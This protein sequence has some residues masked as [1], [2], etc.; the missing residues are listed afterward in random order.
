MERKKQNRGWMR[1]ILSE[2]T[3]GLGPVPFSSSCRG[4]ISLE[5]LDPF[6][7]VHISNVN[8]RSGVIGT[9]G[10][11]DRAKE[12]YN[13]GARLRGL[14]L[15]RG[16]GGGG[17]EKGGGTGPVSPEDFCLRCKSDTRGCLVFYV[18][19]GMNRMIQ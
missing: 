13:S 18:L 4:V 8:F 6:Q 14:K 11:R 16:I 19:L 15:Y 2:P 5:T 3:L 17:E 7:F 1:R 9:S 12:K 10:W